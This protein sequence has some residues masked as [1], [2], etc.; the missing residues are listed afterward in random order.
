[1]I[2]LDTLL[3]LVIAAATVGTLLTQ[4]GGLPGRVQEPSHPL[5]KKTVFEGLCDLRSRW[6]KA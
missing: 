5:C 2:D 6:S 1:M 3:L 4:L